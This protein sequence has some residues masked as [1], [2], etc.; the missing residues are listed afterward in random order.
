LAIAAVFAFLI[1]LF[2][3]WQVHIWRAGYHLWRD[4][5]YSFLFLPPQKEADAIRNLNRSALFSITVDID[6]RRQFY[7]W[8]TLAFL[9]GFALAG[10]AVRQNRP[11]TKSNPGPST[12]R[13]PQS[14]TQPSQGEPQ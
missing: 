6:W 5:G 12:L 4:S 7:E 14:R 9:T 10:I 11:A 3:H 1:W 8:G 2:P 13:E